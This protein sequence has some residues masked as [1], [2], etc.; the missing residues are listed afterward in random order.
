[1]TALRLMCQGRTAHRCPRHRGRA[2]QSTTHPP[3]VETGRGL[4]EASIP[5]VRRLG[6]PRRSACPALR[7]AAAAE[8]QPRKSSPY[9]LAPKSIRE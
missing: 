8:A 7:S 6:T 3:A 2:E 5:P 4:L 1:M 9:R